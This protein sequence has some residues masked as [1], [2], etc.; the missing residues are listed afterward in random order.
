MSAV[1]LDGRKVAEGVFGA[2]KPRVEALTKKLGRPPVLVIVASE[3]EDPSARAYRQVQEKSCAEIGLSC[4]VVAQR[5]TGADHVLQRLRELAA[6]DAVIV[7]RPL[8]P[9]VDLE[10]LY[11][12]LP[13]GKDAE[14][15]T[16]A[17]LGKLF[18]LKRYADLAAKGLAAP[19]TALAIAELL[20]ATGLP[21]SGKTAAV[22]GR[23]NTVGKP[24]AH[25]LACLDLTVTLCH[26]KTA[27]LPRVVGAADVVVAAVGEAGFVKAGWIKPGAVVL[28]AGINPDGRKV[29][30]DVEPTA[31]ERAAFYT[32]VPGGVG[33]VTT[34]MLLANAVALAERGAREKP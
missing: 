22:V 9:A 7:D 32:P 21:L 20:R 34:A 8:P 28:D 1:P 25:L 12:R 19:C 13:A 10:R 5:W 31:A 2:L 18:A 27:D 17:S 30:G 16:P 23:S 29:Y 33:P 26:S 3:A 15:A 24:A 6:W 14:G 11:D 4:L